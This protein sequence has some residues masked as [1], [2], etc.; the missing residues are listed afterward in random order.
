MHIISTIGPDNATKTVLPFITAKG[1]MENGEGI[2][3]FV[4]QEATYLGSE[5][6]VDLTELKAPGLQPVGEVLNTLR[7]NGA[8]NEFIVCDPC[9][10][11]RNITEEDLR[12]FAEFG[13]APKLAE[14]ATNHETT[15]TF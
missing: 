10:R 6:H 1:A 11:A 3:M 8:L 12:D 7:E 2:D 13:G 9:A 4:M 15:T 5:T 14:Q